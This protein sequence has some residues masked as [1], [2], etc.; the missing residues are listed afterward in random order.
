MRVIVAGSRTITDASL[1]ERVIAES[2]F[3]VTEVVSGGAQGA[4]ALGEQWATRRGIPVRRF[5]ADWRTHGKAAGPAR[6]AEMVAYA[7]ALVA[8]RENASPGTTN[9]IALAMGKRLPVYVI[10]VG[11]GEKRQRSLAFS[12]GRRA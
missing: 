12:P 9:V 4:D 10:D 6:N 7:D 3:D 11:E 1:V 5:P 2:G 8:V